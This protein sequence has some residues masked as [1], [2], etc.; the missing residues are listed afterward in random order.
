M[1][2]S[3]K[4][5]VTSFL[6]LIAPSAQA[7]LPIGLWQS[8]PDPRGVVMHVRTKPCGPA[9]CGRVE[10]AKN[11]QGYDTPSQALG[12]AMLQRMELQED[13][14]Y[15]GKIW[16]PVQ[17]RLLSTRM[18]VQGNRMQLHNCDAQACIDVVWT[19]VR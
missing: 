17:N 11:L 10:R 2:F 3:R 5:A 6:T 8:N 13:G 9:I 12:R 14:S 7:D 15:A 1:T 18:R 16:E 4:L 19:R